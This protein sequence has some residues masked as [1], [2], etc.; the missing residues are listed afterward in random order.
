MGIGKRHSDIHLCLVKTA[1]VRIYYRVSTSLNK[2]C[3]LTC[4]CQSLSC[5]PLMTWLYYVTMSHIG[6]IWSHVSVCMSTCEEPKCTISWCN[7]VLYYIVLY[8]MNA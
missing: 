7:K 5:R 6:L 4:C 1:C 2:I 3:T 8:F